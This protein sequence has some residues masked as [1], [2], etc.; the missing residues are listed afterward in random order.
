MAANQAALR[1][2]HSAQASNRCRYSVDLNKLFSPGPGHELNVIVGVKLLGAEALWHA[3]N[4]NPQQ[5]V[6]SLLAAGLLADSEAEEPLLLAQIVRVSCW[7]ITARRM[8]DAIALTQMTDG[9]LVSLQAMV[10]KAERPQALL[11]GAA[12]DRAMGIAA[13]AEPVNVWPPYSTT[14]CLKDDLVVGLSKTTGIF[15][16]DRTFYLEALG[17]SI[18]AASLPFP[19]RLKL[20]QQTPGGGA[21]PR[22]CTISPRLLPRIS[23]MFASEADMAA[24]LRAAQV[25]L[26]VERFRSRHQGRLPAS[27]EELAP[28]FCKALPADPFDGKPLRLTVLDS[29]YAIYTSGTD[30]RNGGPLGFQI[31]WP[32]GHSH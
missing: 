29:G 30:A 14:E 6:S 2:L 5:A 3:A 9:Q 23:S 15:E 27:L 24:R 4:G 20:G 8:E 1:L 25:A 17:T 16:L 13:F 18:A 32:G 11:R 19:E 10:A 7:S 26:A 31:F 12:G 28:D 21:A 22:F